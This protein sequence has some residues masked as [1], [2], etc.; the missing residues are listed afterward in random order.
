MLLEA[1]F[2]FKKN[3]VG[4]ERDR[5]EEKTSENKLLVLS[6]L[7]LDVHLFASAMIMGPRMHLAMVE[8]RYSGMHIDD[9]LKFFQHAPATLSRR[10]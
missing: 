2:S 5:S 10:L 1:C 8:K 9:G 4:A 7:S 3:R 6:R